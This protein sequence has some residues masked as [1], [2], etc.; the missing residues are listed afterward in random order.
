M[1]VLLAD[2]TGDLLPQQQLLS[3]VTSGKSEGAKEQ[4]TNYCE[5][6]YSQSVM[7]SRQSWWF[8]GGDV[9]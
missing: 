6:S 5:L 9:E 4:R 7:G 8:E 2:K 1:L 3:A